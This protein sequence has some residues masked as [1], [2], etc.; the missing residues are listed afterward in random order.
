[1]DRFKGKAPQA[2]ARSDA[3]QR[4]STVASGDGLTNAI[5][6]DDL[7]QAGWRRIAGLRLRPGDRTGP[8]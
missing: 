5:D 7:P 4:Y 3:R 8:A 1:M 2:P 6:R